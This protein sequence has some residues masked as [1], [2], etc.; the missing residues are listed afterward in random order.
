[1]Q[2]HAALRHGVMALAGVVLALIVAAPAT[3]ADAASLSIIAPPGAQAASGKTYGDWSAVW[4]QVMMAIPV[5]SNPTFDL[6][7]A[8]CSGGNTAAIFFLA[9]QGTGETVTRSCTVPTTKPLFFPIINV[10]CS[11][12][13][14][15]PFF[16]ATDEDR[17]ACARRI[18]DGIG[19]STLHV[20]LDGAA[21]GNPSR[22][23]AASPPFNFTIPRNDNILFVRGVTSGRSASDGYW[24]LLNPPSPGTHT[25]HFEGAFVS[26]V[27]TPFSQNVTYNLTAQ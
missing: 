2:A 15:P 19:V 7:G 14:K 17:E 6:T 10:E 25:I 26:G 18:A 12:V 27:G 8:N 11:N 22:L 9:G 20:T 16:G 1:M 3:L 5:E 4:W 21:V 24:V 13:E 23:R